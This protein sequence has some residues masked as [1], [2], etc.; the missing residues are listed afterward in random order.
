MK[1]TTASSTATTSGWC[2]TYHDQE[3]AAVAHHYHETEA[4]ADG[5]DIQ[6]Y[7][8]GL[9]ASSSKAWCGGSFGLLWPFIN[10]GMLTST[11]KIMHAIG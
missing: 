3:E 10:D 8:Q 9:V 6:Y 1:A 7:K 5:Q 11:Q 2:S 4:A